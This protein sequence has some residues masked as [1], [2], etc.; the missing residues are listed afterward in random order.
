LLQNNYKV[1][2]ICAGA[3]LCPPFSLARPNVLVHEDA[4]PLAKLERGGIE[5]GS[6]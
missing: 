6:A 5:L 2:G 1:E 3:R 4:N